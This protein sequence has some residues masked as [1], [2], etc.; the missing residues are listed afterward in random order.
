MLKKNERIELRLDCND[1]TEYNEKHKEG[2]SASFD[3]KGGISGIA[4]DL[5]DFSRK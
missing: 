1:V 3:K 5:A 2:K 4:S